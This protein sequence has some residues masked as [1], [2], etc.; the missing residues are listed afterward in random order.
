MTSILQLV[1]NFQVQ[2]RQCLC[3]YFRPNWNEFTSLHQHNLQIQNK[4]EFVTSLEVL[5]TIY[6]QNPTSTNIKDIMVFA[7]T[8]ITRRTVTVVF[9]IFCILLWQDYSLYRN[10]TIYEESNL[11]A[12]YHWDTDV[13]A[14]AKINVQLLDLI[15]TRIVCIVTGSLFFSSLSSQ[16]KGVNILKIRL[17][18][19]GKPVTLSVAVLGFSFW[20]P[21]WGRHFHLGAHNWYFRAELPG[22]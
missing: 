3:L 11:A 19:F 12:I 1:R 4:H 20:G 10:Q 14:K 15:S 16:P 22:M 17:Y 18:H 7:F 21:F 9:H 2:R 8:F 13:P 5:L 6:S